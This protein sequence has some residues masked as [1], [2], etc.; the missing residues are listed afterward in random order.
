MYELK[1]GVSPEELQAQFAEYLGTADPVPIGVILHAVEDQ[2]FRSNLMLCRNRPDML[3]SLFSNPKNVEFEEQYRSESKL[4]GDTQAELPGQ[5]GT[6]EL[7]GRASKAVFSWAKVGF[8]NV[9]MATFERRFSACQ[10]CDMLSD[11]PTKMIYKLVKTKHTDPRI[12]GACGCVASRKARMASE[13]CPLASKE[14]SQ[15]NRWGEPLMEVVGADHNRL[16]QDTASAN[17]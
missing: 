14:D 10:G 3:R 5:H 13:S 8:A 16:G 4:G 7:L 17:A 6:L 12:C 2:Y 1:P 15:L 9:D 11:P